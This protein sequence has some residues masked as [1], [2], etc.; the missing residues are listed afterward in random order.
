M[1]TVQNCEEEKMRKK[2]KKCILLS[3]IMFIC[4]TNLVVPSLAKVKM[5][6]KYSVC[7]GVFTFALGVVEMNTCEIALL[8]W[9]IWISVN[10][11]IW[12]LVRAKRWTRN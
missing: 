1:S 11:A 2:K 6:L 9:F 7:K 3:F 8:L 4:G 10:T 5:L 12:T